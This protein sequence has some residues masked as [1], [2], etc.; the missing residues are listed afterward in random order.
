MT[1][2]ENVW[3][4]WSKNKKEAEFSIICAKNNLFDV[5]KAL[6]DLN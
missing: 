1:E 5:L 3:E 6:I 4:S 2:T